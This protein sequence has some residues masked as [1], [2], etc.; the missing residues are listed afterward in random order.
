MT[1]LPTRA[2]S[3]REPAGPGRGYPP[4]RELAAIGDGRTIALI[5]LDGTICWLPLPS[6]DSPT[7]FGSLLDAERGGR[8]T[9]APSEPSEVRRRYLPDTNVLETTF[10]TDSGVARVVDAMTLKLG[11]G[12]AP[13]REVVRIVEGIEGS[14]RF[15]WALQPRFRSEEHTS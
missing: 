3:V 12:L 6:L 5:S 1:V 7:V 13:F 10:T 4:I 14:V 2:G 8:F 15:S 11:S 9:L